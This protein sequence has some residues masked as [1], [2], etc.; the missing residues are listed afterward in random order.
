M[1]G[2]EG[3]LFQFTGR[4]T[5]RPRI[6]GRTASSSMLSGLDSNVTNGRLVVFPIVISPIH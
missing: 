3:T 2:G 1:D 6:E 4:E 5:A